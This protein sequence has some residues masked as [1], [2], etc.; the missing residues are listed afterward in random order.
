MAKMTDEDIRARKAT[1]IRLGA[2]VESR[3]SGR[4]GL[5]VGANPSRNRL[6]VR[7]DGGDDSTRCDVDFRDLIQIDD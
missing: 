5:V 1:L 4:R 2:R 7:W 6:T 3:I